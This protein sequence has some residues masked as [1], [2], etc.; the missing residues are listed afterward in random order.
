MSI[1][2][3][4]LPGALLAAALTLSACADTP[5]APV[6]A[7]AAPVHTAAPDPGHAR[8]AIERNNAALVRAFVDGDAD[9]AAALFTGDAVL[10]L[11][12]MEAVTGRDAI[13]DALSASF[14]AV[15]FLDI[16]WHILEVTVHGDMAY[17]MGTTEMTYRVGGETV[18]VPGKYLVA[19]QRQ[20]GGDWKIHRDISNGSR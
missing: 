7:E 10:M 15:D 3:A 2:R 4:T 8:A 9:A 5:S 6:R 13:R 20:P 1:T 12:G 14:G 17:E 18:T 16:R 19:W 11:A